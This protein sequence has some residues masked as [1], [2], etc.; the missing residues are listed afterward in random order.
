MQIWPADS[1][2]KGA[3]WNSI[4][5]GPAAPALILALSSVAESKTTFYSSRGSHFHMLT[6]FL[7]HSYINIVYNFYTE[8]CWQC[9]SFS[10]SLLLMPSY[11][12]FSFPHTPVSHSL[13]LL[14]LMPSNPCFSCPIPLLLMPSYPC[15][16]SP[17]APV[18]Q[19]LIPLF[20]MPSFPCFSCPHAPFSHVLMPLFLMHSYPCFSCHHD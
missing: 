2:A 10:H 12:C 13:I 16:S 4:G 20:L 18:S 17:H 19:A 7:L 11:P 3:K 8:L 9:F 14:F 6:T 1:L 15:F 5:R